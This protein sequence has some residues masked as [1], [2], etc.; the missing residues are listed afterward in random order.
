[1]IKNLDLHS[2]GRMRTR[3][4]RLYGPSE[5]D[6]LMERMVS[7]IGRYG[8]GLEGYSKKDLWNERTAVLITY[9]D[10][11]QQGEEPPLQVL[12]RFADRYLSG[13][14]DTIHIL[15]FC[16]YSSAFRPTGA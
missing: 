16:P 12:K 7:L 13:A 15:P 10:M 2:L 3:F 4:N 6:R 8:I 9:G 5:V 11:I 14:I 1:M